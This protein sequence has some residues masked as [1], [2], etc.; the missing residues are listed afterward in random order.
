ME[1]LSAS[2]SFAYSSGT[3]APIGSESAWKAAPAVVFVKLSTSVWSSGVVMPLMSGA[4]VG[5]FS[6]AF[7]AA[8]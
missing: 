7:C 4:V 5:S 1:G 3:G 2:N 6:T 8:A